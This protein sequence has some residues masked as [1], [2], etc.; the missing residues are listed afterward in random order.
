MDSCLSKQQCGFRK[1][2][3]AQYCLLVM[4]E[5]RKSAIDKGKYLEAL[6]MDLFKTLDC[7]SHD[8]LIAKLHV[9][10]FDLPELRLI[11][12]YLSNRKQRTKINVTH[13]SLEEILFGV[14]QGS[15]LGPLLFNIFL[16]D[17]FWIMCRTD[18]ESYAVDNTSYV[19]GDSIDDV[20]KSFKDDSMNLFKWFL[21]N[22]MK[23]NSDKYYLITSKQ[24]LNLKIGNI[25]IENST[26][27]KIQGV[28]VN[29]KILQCNK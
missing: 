8:L 4:L 28:K 7:L 1:G 9:D 21:D 14:P 22:H 25:S 27:E 17:L 19:S 24:I 23:V 29:N 20:I 5:K 16:C 2:Y 11:Q 6:L 18:S 10:V 26:C 12:S 15:V 13:S 3:S